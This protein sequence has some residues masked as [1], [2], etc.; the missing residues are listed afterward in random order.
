MK[1]IIV[2]LFLPLLL[3]GC[4]SKPFSED[5]FSQKGIA[6]Y[7]CQEAVKEKIFD[8]SPK[9]EYIDYS[10]INKNGM[11]FDVSGSFESRNK[12]GVPSK[13][14]YDCTV[15][16]SQYNPDETYTTVKIIKLSIY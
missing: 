8:A 9:F 2:G 4:S 3:S 10:T 13:L 11:I 16:L 5:I 7:E 1:K 12:F 15:D 14:T 6:K